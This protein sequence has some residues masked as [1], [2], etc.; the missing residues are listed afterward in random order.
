MVMFLILKNPMGL[1]LYKTLIDTKSFEKG[2]STKNLK[3]MS[4]VYNIWKR[5]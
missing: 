1:N 3:I 5:L 2:S 4:K